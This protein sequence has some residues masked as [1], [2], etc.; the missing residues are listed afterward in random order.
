MEAQLSCRGTAL[1]KFSAEP[2]DCVG[3]VPCR[4]RYW[5]LI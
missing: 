3:T 2:K 1:A 5:E 4:H